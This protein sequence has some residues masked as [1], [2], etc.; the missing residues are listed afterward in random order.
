MQ[1]P[2]E[3]KAKA[4]EGDGAARDKMVFG[5]VFTG[6]PPVRIPTKWYAHLR[7]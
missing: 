2:L 1:A 7:G 3:P 4:S 5:D 6:S